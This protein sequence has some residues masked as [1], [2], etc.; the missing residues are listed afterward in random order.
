MK[1]GAVTGVVLAD[2]TEIAG[3]DRRLRRRSAAHV[4]R[5]IDPVELEPDFMTRIRNY[6]C[7]GTVAKLNFALRGLPAFRGADRRSRRVRCAAACTSAR[8]STISSARS[9][10]RSTARRRRRRISTSRSRRSPIRRWRRRAG[11]SCRCTCSTRRSRCA[12][13]RG[14]ARRTRSRTSCCARSR[15]TRPASPRLVEHRQV[16][17]AARSRADRTA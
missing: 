17:H 15:P 1:D 11:T 9:T 5:L 3:D 4:P 14:T 10:R 2:G 12:P 16:H 6:R 13:A 7:P 8:A